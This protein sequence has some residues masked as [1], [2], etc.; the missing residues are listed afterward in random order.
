MPSR[1]VIGAVL[2]APSPITLLRNAAKVRISIGHEAV[3][4]CFRPQVVLRRPVSRRLKSR[5]AGPAGWKGRWATG[6]RHMAS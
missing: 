4:C 3:L 2:R 6:K 1:L 5:P